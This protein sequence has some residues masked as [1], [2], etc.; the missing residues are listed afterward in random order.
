[1]DRVWDI[2]EVRKMCFLF[3]KWGK[4]SEV[5]FET[6]MRRCDNGKEYQYIKE[7]Q[8]RT[9]LKCEKIQKRYI[10]EVK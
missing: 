3:H 7:S 4:W 1:M 8:L 6:F 9:C 10:K 5:R 2:R